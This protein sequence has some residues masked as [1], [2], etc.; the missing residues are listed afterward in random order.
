MLVT[1]YGTF[2]Q[3]VRRKSCGFR[4]I[5]IR[6]RLRVNGQPERSSEADKLMAGHARAY[7]YAW[8]RLVGLDYVLIDLDKVRAAE[9]IQRAMKQGRDI[10]NRDNLTSFTWVTFAELAQADAIIDI[11]LRS[12]LAAAAPQPKWYANHCGKRMN[13]AVWRGRGS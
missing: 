1:D 6:Y 8:V 9:L 5:T 12:F 11:N 3:R 4:D 7:I 2:A 13:Y 10:R